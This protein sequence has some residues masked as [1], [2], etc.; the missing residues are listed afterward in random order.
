MN[1]NYIHKFN[2]KFM[3]NNKLFQTCESTILKY[4]N[5]VLKISFIP[6]TDDG[7]RLHDLRHT[8]VVHLIEKWIKEESD[9]NALLPILQTHMGHKSLESLSY[10]FHLTHDLLNQVNKISED[11]LGYLIPRL[12]NSHE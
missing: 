12:E 4:F 10:Y 6:K 11:Y 5:K 2:Y 3:D 1:K 8:F 9:I 7:P